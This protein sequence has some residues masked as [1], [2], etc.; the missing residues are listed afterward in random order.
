MGSIEF[1]VPILH[2]SIVASWQLVHPSPFDLQLG[3]VTGSGQED[4]SRL[5]VPSCAF[6]ISIIGVSL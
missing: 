4:I 2:P 1:W 3:H 6:V 5:D